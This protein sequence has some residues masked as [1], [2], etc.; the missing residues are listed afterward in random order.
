MV[1]LSRKGTGAKQDKFCL[2]LNPWG[3]YREKPNALHSLC[4]YGSKIQVPNGNKEYV[5]DKKKK[6]TKTKLKEG[7]LQEG[8]INGAAK[9]Q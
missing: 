4:Y 9:T 5:L 1:A 8:H 3:H 7:T 2:P 6:T